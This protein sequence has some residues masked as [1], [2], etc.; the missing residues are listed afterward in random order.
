METAAGK[1]EQIGFYDSVLEDPSAVFARAEAYRS[2]S[3]ADVQR[4]AKRLFDGRARVVVEVQP[5]APK[6]TKPNK[7]S[8]SVQEEAR[9]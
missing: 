3:P 8:R 5:A 7:R 4:V 1:A 2:M 6:P 9:A